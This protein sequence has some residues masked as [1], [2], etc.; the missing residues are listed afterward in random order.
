MALKE[1]ANPSYDDNL[2]DLPVLLD[3][4]PFPSLSARGYTHG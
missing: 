2:G 1:E 4:E 3:R